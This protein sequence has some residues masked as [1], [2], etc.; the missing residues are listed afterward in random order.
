MPGRRV[1]PS[2]LCVAAVFATTPLADAAPLLPLGCQT[3]GGTIDCDVQRL[4]D[5]M[6]TSLAAQKLDRWQLNFVEGTTNAD[7]A[8]LAKLPS[9]YFMVIRSKLVDDLTP[10]TK[11]TKLV[12]LHLFTPK[13][14]SIAPLEK[15]KTLQILDV[16]RT[17]VSDVSPIGSSKKLRQLFLGPTVKDLGPIAT[18]SGLVTLHLT[19][20]PKDFAPLVGHPKLEQLTLET[21]S[22]KDLKPLASLT[23]LHAVR[24][25]KMPELA[26]LSAIASMTSLRELAI[27]STKVS[28]LSVLAGMTQLE[29]IDLEGVP[30]ASLAPLAKLTHLERVDLRGTKVK[31]LTPLLASAKSLQQLRAPEGTTDAQLEPFRKANPNIWFNEAD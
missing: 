3:L 22:W 25:F 14:E 20:P 17:R 28:D 4:D 15:V 12:I 21:F 1:A 10:L 23:T 8:T 11:T 2:L 7:L 9:A 6:V 13:L 16:Q 27:P 19:A 24:C 5:A 18:M 29:V 31:D 30:I 26:D